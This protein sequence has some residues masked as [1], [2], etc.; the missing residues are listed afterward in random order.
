MLR[1]WL[2]MAKKI[3]ADGEIGICVL[4]DGTE[5][6]E[7]GFFEGKVGEKFSYCAQKGYD[8]NKIE[9]SEKCQSALSADCSI[10]VTK[11]GAEVEVSKLMEIELNHLSDK[12]DYCNPDMK[13]VDPDCQKVNTLETGKTELIIQ[14]NNKNMIYIIIL[15]IS[16]IA[17][18]LIVLGICYLKKKKTPR[19]T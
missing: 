9:K 3:T 15:I 10:C 4:P 17:L 1:H 5:V 7:W 11:E 6:E 13:D 2:L 12:D 18:A 14:K 16:I 8:I 19:D